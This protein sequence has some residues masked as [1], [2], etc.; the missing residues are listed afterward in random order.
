MR[1]VIIHNIDTYRDGGTV[2]IWATI[3]WNDEKYSHTNEPTITI[4]YSISSKQN[5]TE[6]GW[7]WGWKNKGGIMIENEELKDK[8]RYRIHEYITILVNLYDNKINN[9][10]K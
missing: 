8:V 3:C 7:Y 9:N 1:S 6:G 10:D 2:G 5:N 4:D